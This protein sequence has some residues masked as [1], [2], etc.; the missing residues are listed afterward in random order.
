LKWR[1]LWKPQ[2]CRKANELHLWHTEFEKAG[3]TSSGDETGHRCTILD[4]RERSELD[5]DST[6]MKVKIQ[7]RMRSP[8]K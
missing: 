4:V 6:S 7:T 3:R 5:I 2:V 1:T 8:G